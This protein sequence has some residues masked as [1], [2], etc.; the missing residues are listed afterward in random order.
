MSRLRFRLLPRCRRLPCLAAWCAA[1]S[2]LLSVGCNLPMSRLALNGP[3]VPGPLSSGLTP[4]LSLTSVPYARGT[5]SRSAKAPRASDLVRASHQEEEDGDEDTTVPSGPVLNLDTVLR[6]TCERNPE[7]LL[8]RER[9]NESQIALDAAL[10]SCMPELL[11]KDLFKRPVAEA[12]VWRRRAEL[13]K[14]QFDA[15]QDAANTYFDWLT[16]LRGETVA[17]DLEKYEEK[18]LK[19]SRALIESGEK[20]AQVLVE[21]T[22]TALNGRRQFSARARQLGQAAAAKLAYLLGLSDAGP[23]PA[24]PALEPIDLVDAAAPS[25]A[26]VQQA[27]DNGPGVREL[28][29]LAASIQHGLDDARALSVCATAL[30]PPW[31]AADCKSPRASC[32][33]PSWR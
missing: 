10:R 2:L 33:R 30:A 21:A 16:A 24:A 5:W 27:M 15:L 25:A 4:P 18:L 17:R 6:L 28:Q 8:A 26:L 7:I 14:K 9:V 23:A 32:N 19:R 20:P 12:Q 22:Q 11:R 1:G 29:G 31:C 3:P 13:S